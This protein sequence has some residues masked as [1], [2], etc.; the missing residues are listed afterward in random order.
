MENPIPYNEWPKWVKLASAI[1]TKRK[2]Y[3]DPKSSKFMSL[4]IVGLGLYILLCFDQ[5]S[6]MHEYN[7]P[8]MDH[9]DFLVAGTGFFAIMFGLFYWLF[10]SK[11]FDWIQTNSSPKERMLHSSSKEDKISFLAILVGIIILSYVLAKVFQ[12]YMEM[13]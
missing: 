8:R 2:T 7:P 6:L 4:F 12:Y 13:V 3:T 10:V 1:N 9:V 5:F 11:A